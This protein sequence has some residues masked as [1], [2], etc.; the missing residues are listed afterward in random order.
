MITLRQFCHLLLLGIVCVFSSPVS[1]A[2]PDERDRQVLETL[3]LHLLSDTKF[4]VTRVPTN[5]ATIVLH[6]RTPEKTGFLESH[7]IR[8]EIGDHQLPGD[9]ERDLRKRN[10]RPNAKPDTYEAVAA[11]YTNLTFAA[12]ILVTNLADIR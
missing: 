7:Q 5:Q 1:A 8:G 12:G 2:P 6:A 11:T 4:D 9:A 3:L 10:S